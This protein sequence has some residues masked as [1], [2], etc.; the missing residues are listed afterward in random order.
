MSEG[1][2]TLIHATRAAA[3]FT[4]VELLVVLLV[5]A[6]LVGLGV[7]AMQNLI[8]DNQLNAVTDNFA[9]ALNSARGE[10]GKLGTNVA[11]STT[12]GWGT[13]WT[14]SYFD[15]TANTTVTLRTG[16]KLPTGYTLKSTA[17]LASSL[18]F[19]STGRLVSG[20]AAGQFVICQGDPWSS[21]GGAA[22]M[23][24]VMPTGR[25][26]IAQNNSSGKPVDD[27]NNQIAGCTP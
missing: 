24:T 6:I 23:I 14:L 8:A 17:N 26:R 11:L 7:P 16:S 13:D 22:R 19:D 3:G 4:L 1:T 12:N 21:A 2:E 5:G 18:S 9:S 15:T 27:N 20:T 25:V 10:A